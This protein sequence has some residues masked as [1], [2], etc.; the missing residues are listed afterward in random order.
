MRQTFGLL[1]LAA[2]L[3]AVPAAG[4]AN[5]KVWA[6]LERGVLIVNTADAVAQSV[7]EHCLMV[8]LA[9]LRRLTEADRIMHRGGW[10]RPGQTRRPSPTVAAARRLLRPALV[11]VAQ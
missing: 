7:A 2:V 5:P 3:M 8:S 10:P 4:A 1:V 6:L 11:L 9:A